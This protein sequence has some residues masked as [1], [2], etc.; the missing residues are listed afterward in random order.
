MC[1]R[2]LIKL[3]EGPT[4]IR[5]PRIPDFYWTF[6]TVYTVEAW[7]YK[8]VIKSPRERKK[9]WS[10]QA[11]AVMLNS[12]LR[13]FRVGLTAGEIKTEERVTVQNT[14]FSRRQKISQQASLQSRM[15][16]AL[17]V[18][19]FTAKHRCTGSLS[20]IGHRLFYFGITT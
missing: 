10:R 17:C 13:N 4:T 8:K 7:R 11:L 16:H 12:V 5:K 18:W 2:G 20:Y 3:D 9:A 14:G 6:T 15:L 1:T 19:L